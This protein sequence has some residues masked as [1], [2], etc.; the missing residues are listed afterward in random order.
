[1]DSELQALE[2]DPSLVAWRRRATDV[3]FLAWVPLHLATAVIPA[4]LLRADLGAVLVGTLVGGWLMTVAAAVFRGLDHRAR[5]WL[6]LAAMYATSLFGSLEI[7]DGPML[8]AWPILAPI[9][10]IGLVGRRAGRIS[11]GISAAVLLAAPIVLSSPVASE[12][13]RIGLPLRGTVSPFLL[14]Q[15][16]VLIAEMVI[17]T[18]L[19]D[20]LHNY[21]L[22]S[23][24]AERRTAR[25]Q[26][27]DHERLETVMRQQI[28]LERDLATVGDE[29]RRRLGNDL[30]DGVSQQLAGALLRCHAMEIGLERGSSVSV[31][32]VRA[33]SSLLDRT[34]AETHVVAHGLWPLD[35]TPMALVAGLGRR[36]PCELQITGSVEFDDP[37]VAQH[38]YRIA[39][40]ALGNAVH[41][42]RAER[43]LI[44][45]SGTEEL[46]TLRVEDNGT[47]F[48]PGDPTGGL[49]LRTMAHRARLIGG[50]LDIL[51][52]AGG[53]TRVECH[54]PRALPC[55]HRPEASS[56]HEGGTA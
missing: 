37:V 21:L 51:S 50:L 19:V 7:P 17:V 11:M 27:A 47:G 15:G 54:V 2:R 8:R 45:L 56:A 30:H 41:H 49:G 9:L 46:V 32:D 6:F 40:E 48:I 16:P 33:L 18:I 36:V 23:L 3:V 43:I 29:E 34:I 25:D 52:D 55:D 12:L 35:A 10:A 39:Q 31:D 53:G 13:H 22:R 14:V 20:Q 28:Q 26:A 24:L 38:L 4:V 44:E 1:M 5:V 42:A